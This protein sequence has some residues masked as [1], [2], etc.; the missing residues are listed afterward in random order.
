MRRGFPDPVCQACKLQAPLPLKPK[1]SIKY[2]LIVLKCANE[3]MKQNGDQ[4]ARRAATARE[5]EIVRFV[6]GMF[7]SD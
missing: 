2:P 4:L 6:G 7:R 1:F 3:G 5:I